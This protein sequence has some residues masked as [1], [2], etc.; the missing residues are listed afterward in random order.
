MSK[1]LQKLLNILDLEKIDTNI[2]RGTTPE[3]T[4]SRVFGG[5]V[6]AQAMRA[7]QDT[8]DKERLV[9]SQHAY[10]PV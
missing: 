7:A 2:Y 1:A 9:H 10:C 3:T 8:V 6:F 5:Q 4:N